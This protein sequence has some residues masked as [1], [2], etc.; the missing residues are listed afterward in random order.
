MD[1]NVGDERSISVANAAS[2]AS[3]AATS[4]ES[5]GE[6]AFATA[7]APEQSRLQFDL[8]QL[9]REKAAIHRG[10][11]IMRGDFEDMHAALFATTPSDAASPRFNFYRNLARS[12]PAQLH[13][14]IT[15]FVTA[16][17]KKEEA[18]MEK[19]KAI[20][21][22]QIATPQNKDHT[23]RKRPRSA[24]KL[25]AIVSK[26]ASF[27]HLRQRVF[28]MAEISTAF[29]GNIAYST[30]VSADSDLCIELYFKGETDARTMETT[31]VRALR[32]S[33]R[34]DTIP[35]INILEI[36][37]ELQRRVWKQDYDRSTSPDRVS[38]DIYEEAGR[39]A[40]T[41]VLDAEEI[42]LESVVD[43][44]MTDLRFERCHINASIKG[45]HADSEG[46]WI[47]L[48]V[49]W[50]KFFD[51]Y[52]IDN[53]ALVSIVGHSK[54]PDEKIGDREGVVVHVYFAPHLRSSAFYSGQLRNATMVR[55]GV[56]AVTV[57]KRE[58]DKFIAQL[59]TRHDRVTQSWSSVP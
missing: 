13:G 28:E 21:A 47:P 27:Q 36:E 3:A 53:K 24:W 38:W 34:S 16:I 35:L 59:Q 33:W 29:D 2:S 45:T 12:N 40:A 44:K 51:A 37:R 52:T 32:E 7:N 17:A 41:T 48:P 10:L 5:A 9:T 22:L 49:D 6:A 54:I 31:L 4:V 25:E 43:D 11:E 8:D 1:P 58:A 42:A 15:Q 55:K 50:H 57:W 56:F 19:E 39:S 26:G 30:P 20:R 23:Y 18:I 14:N 46:N